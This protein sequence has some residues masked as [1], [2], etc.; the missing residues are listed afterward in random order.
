MPKGTV[1]RKEQSGIIAK[2]VKSTEHILL[3][4]PGIYLLMLFDN[5]E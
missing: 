1:F 3:E 5:C 2:Q 4:K